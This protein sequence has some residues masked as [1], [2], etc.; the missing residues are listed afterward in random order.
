M[1]K[2]SRLK[3]TGRRHRGGRSS[4]DLVKSTGIDNP[5]SSESDR[6]QKKGQVCGFGNACYNASM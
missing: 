3:H 6:A 5:A 4:P 1:K 2:H